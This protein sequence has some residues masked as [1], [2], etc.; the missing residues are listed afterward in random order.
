M[1]RKHGARAALVSGGVI[2]IAATGLC[3]L[4]SAQRRAIIDTSRSLHCRLRSVDLSDVRWTDGFWKQ[5]FDLVESVTIPKMW[6]YFNRNDQTE[7]G[8]HW[9]NFRIAAGLQAGPWKGRS[10]HDGDFYKWLE[11]VAYVYDVTGDPTL[12]RQMDEVIDVIGRAQ[13]P[14]GYLSTQIIVQKLG[15][16]Q[17]IHH[18]ELYNMGHLMTAACIHHRMTGKD[19]FL[20]IAR[21]TGDYL[22]ETFKTRRPE[23]APFGFNPSNIMGAVELYRT[24]GDVKYLELANIFID[25]RG[26]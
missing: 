16:F 15:R 21:K 23:L 26:T 5:K 6:E 3:R 17:N 22:F 12:D 8:H 2:L 24:T 10:W 19:N 13:Q 9:I 11:A 4:A 25:N 20:R 1:T 7:M 18:H 14:D